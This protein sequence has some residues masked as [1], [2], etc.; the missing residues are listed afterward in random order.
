MRSPTFVFP[1][2]DPKRRIDVDLATLPF[3]ILGKMG[4]EAHAYYMQERPEAKANKEI[5]SK[6]RTRPGDR[7]RE[8]DPW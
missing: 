4:D 6:S 1:G 7:L 3:E 2:F 5:D 8:K